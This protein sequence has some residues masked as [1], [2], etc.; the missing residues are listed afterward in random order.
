MIGSEL[1]INMQWSGCIFIAESEQFS[2]INVRWGRERL[3]DV[4]CIAT[5]AEFVSQ[6]LG[7]KFSF[8]DRFH[9]WDAAYDVHDIMDMQMDEHAEWQ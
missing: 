8:A 3:V 6:N 4:D 5:T 2:V 1:R 7:D 9:A